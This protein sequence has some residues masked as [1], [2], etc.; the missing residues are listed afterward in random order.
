MRKEAFFILETEKEEEGQ[1]H[2]DRYRADSKHRVFRFYPDFTL[3]W[4]II[5]FSG[6]LGGSVG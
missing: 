1:A 2:K 6:H 3:S 5:A 4:K